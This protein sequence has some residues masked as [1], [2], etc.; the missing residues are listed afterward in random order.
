ML[1]RNDI[2]K[3]TDFYIDMLK[4]TSLHDSFHLILIYLSLFP[5]PV[6]LSAQPSSFPPTEKYRMY[7]L[8]FF[9]HSPINPLNNIQNNNNNSFITTYFSSLSSFFLSSLP[10]I[11]R[12]ICRSLLSYLQQHLQCP[13]NELVGLIPSQRILADQ[14]FFSFLFSSFLFLSLS[15]I[16]PLFLSFLPFSS[17]PL[18]LSFSSSIFY[19]IFSFF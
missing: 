15:P 10:S 13:Q 1:F 9:S 14:V 12:C 17:I 19:L 4:S 8:H 16:L 7:S 5:F 3:N 2:T 6:F 11:S 18:F